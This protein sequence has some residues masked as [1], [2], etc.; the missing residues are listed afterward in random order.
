MVSQIPGMSLRAVLTWLSMIH[1][2]DFFGEESA[3]PL[4]NPETA[5]F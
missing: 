1:P 4:F 2:M 3:N 5:C